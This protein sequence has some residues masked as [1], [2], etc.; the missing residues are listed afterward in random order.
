MCAVPH[1][2]PCSSLAVIVSAPSSFD[3]RVC[4]FRRP[5]LSE[6]KGTVSVV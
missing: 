5:T 1:A 4:S 6:A 3:L 2:F